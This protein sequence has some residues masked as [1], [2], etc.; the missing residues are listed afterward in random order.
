MASLE[1]GTERDPE[2][3]ERLQA[4]ASRVVLAEGESKTVTLILMP[5]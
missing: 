2:L 4:R 1:T 3:L 5:Q